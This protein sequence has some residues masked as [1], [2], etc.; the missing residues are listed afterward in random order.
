MPRKVTGPSFLQQALEV[1][2]SYSRGVQGRLQETRSPY[3]F[4]ACPPK[5]LILKQ[6]ERSY[7]FTDTDKLRAK[8]K[9]KGV[10]LG[11]V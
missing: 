10:K 5:L 6:G 4:K 3:G 11:A 9:E 1:L 2:D 7:V 8:L